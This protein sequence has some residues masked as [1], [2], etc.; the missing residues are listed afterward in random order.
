MGK[1]ILLLFYSIAF[2]SLEILRQCANLSTSQAY[3]C[4]V[5]RK[6]VDFL[7]CSFKNYLDTVCPASA[8]Q[9]SSMSPDKNVCY[10]HWKV[11]A[12]TSVQLPRS[13]PQNHVLKWEDQKELAEIPGRRL[14]GR[15]LYIMYVFLNLFHP[16]A[17][18]IL[19][20]WVEKFWPF[21]IEFFICEAGKI[22]M[23]SL[24]NLFPVK[25]PSNI[26]Q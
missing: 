26:I 13:R 23:T 6:I 8:S 25:F 1:D 5:I 11:L 14:K 20:L 2:C 15:C 21:S 7:R 17:G 9:Y 18:D 24:L 12:V 3:G 10:F 22:L 4:E 16:K 19:V